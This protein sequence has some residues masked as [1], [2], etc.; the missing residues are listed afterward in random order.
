MHINR[1]A[2]ARESLLRVVF[3]DSVVSLVLA[4]HA[5]FAEVALSFE[6]L[7]SRHHGNPLLIEIIL[8]ELPSDY[9]AA[10]DCMVGGAR[11]NPVQVH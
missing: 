6:L 7:A 5:T 3:D 4:A 2:G 1:S 11:F 8:P 10:F 9:G